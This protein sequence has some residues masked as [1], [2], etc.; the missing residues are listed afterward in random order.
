M[1]VARR[2]EERPPPA[3][4][5]NVKGD[6]IDDRDTIIQD[7]VV[8][9]SN[10]GTGEKSKAEELREAKALLDDGIIDDAEFKQM[11]KEILGK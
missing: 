10:I 4:I 5:I 3:T 6:Y 9:R 2:E 1:E 8:S 7:S 11:K